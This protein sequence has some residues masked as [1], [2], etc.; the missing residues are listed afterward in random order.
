MCIDYITV[1]TFPLRCADTA[2]QLRPHFMPLDVTRYSLISWSKKHL[3][4]RLTAQSYLP[5][6]QWGC[7]FPQQ[8][9]N[10]LCSSKW[11]ANMAQPDGTMSSPRPSFSDKGR[12]APTCPYLANLATTQGESQKKLPSSHKPMEH[13]ACSR[14]RG[15]AELLPLRGCLMLLVCVSPGIAFPCQSASKHALWASLWA[16]AKTVQR[17][18]ATSKRGWKERIKKLLKQL[19]TRQIESIEFL[20]FGALY[21]DGPRASKS[22]SATKSGTSL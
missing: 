19:R 13:S 3:L 14:L 10:A 15:F 21:K 17:E 6:P 4:R 22:D 18:S 2:S 9:G 8:E 12:S 1:F 20:H 16:M 7:I 5:L 11:E